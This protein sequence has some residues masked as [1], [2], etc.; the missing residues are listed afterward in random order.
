[1]LR[2]IAMWASAR[3]EFCS[4]STGSILH[5]WEASLIDSR[6]KAPRLEV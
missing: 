5:S 6:S 4:V 1:M 3:D 2:R